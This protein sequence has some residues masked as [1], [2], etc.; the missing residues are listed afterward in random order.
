MATGDMEGLLEDVD[1]R[2]DLFSA[3][4]DNDAS[5]RMGDGTL[6]ISMR[7][8]ALN[9]ARLCKAFRAVISD[10][11]GDLII[12]EGG[13]SRCRD[14]TDHEELF[15]QESFFHWCFGVKEPVWV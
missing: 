8:H 12:L 9:R 14:A 11:E 5:F 6:E 3:S 4:S 13:K 1:L 2:I 10:A 15:R 7:L